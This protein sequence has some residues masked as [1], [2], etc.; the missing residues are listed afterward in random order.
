MINNTRLT[1]VSLIH[2]LRLIEAWFTWYVWLTLFD[3]LT[4]PYILTTTRKFIIYSNKTEAKSVPQNL[5]PGTR[6]IIKCSEAYH[7]G[8][9]AVAI[10]PGMKCA[11]IGCIRECKGITC[12]SLLLNF[13]QC[14]YCIFRCLFWEVF[15]FALPFQNFIM[16]HLA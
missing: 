15:I 13:W 10:N 8:S 7:G 16:L 4:L 3:S 2:Y 11:S 6:V 12:F 9:I 1:I 14:Y 5:C